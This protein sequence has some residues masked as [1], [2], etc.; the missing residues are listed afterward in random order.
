M[1]SNNGRDHR[2]DGRK[3]S[4]YFLVR[5]RR[6]EQRVRL[7]RGW[8]LP[9]RGAMSCGNS[10]LDLIHA[11]FNGL[12]ICRA[13]FTRTC[14]RCTREIYVGT[15]MGFKYP[16][17]HAYCIPCTRQFAV[18]SSQQLETIGQAAAFAHRTKPPKEDE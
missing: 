4:A 10:T 2:G 6:F 16:E 17:K 8:G 12:K 15:D 14:H 18:K 3:I 5:S 11:M 13:G 1:A 7:G 9:G